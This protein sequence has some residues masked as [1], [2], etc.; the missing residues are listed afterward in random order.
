MRQAHFLLLLLFACTS[1]KRMIDT[2]IIDTSIMGGGKRKSTCTCNIGTM[3]VAR[4]HHI[5]MYVQDWAWKSKHLFHTSSYFW[6]FKLFSS[7][8]F[9]FWSFFVDIY[10]FEKLALDGHEFLPMTFPSCT[11]RPAGFWPQQLL[12]R[13]AF[14]AE[15]DAFNENVHL[16]GFLVE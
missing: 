12:L 1:L 9:C 4:E 7:M 15:I 14:D 3:S 5:D 8:S 10:S 11:K 13:N 2:L 6:V 16:M